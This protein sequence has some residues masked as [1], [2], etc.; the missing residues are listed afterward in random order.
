MFIQGLSMF[1]DADW[2][3]PTIPL[4]GSMPRTMASQSFP[5][6]RTFRNAVFSTVSHP[7]S[8]GFAR[9][10]VP[11]RESRTSCVPLSR[12]SSGSSRRTRNRAW[13]LGFALRPKRNRPPV[14]SLPNESSSACLYRARYY[15]LQA[16]RFLSEDPIRFLGGIDLY[17][18]VSALCGFA[19]LCGE[20]CHRCVPLCALRSNGGKHLGLAAGPSAERR[21]KI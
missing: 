18:Y 10:T 8:S 20:S 9:P 19:F 16:G 13:S 5:R 15:D 1:M 12:S 2:G 6:I 3:T 7:S 14:E 4:F 21:G 11:P 17:A